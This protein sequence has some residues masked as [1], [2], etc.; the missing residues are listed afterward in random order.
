MT[1]TNNPDELN[2]EQARTELERVVRALDDPEL[3][4]DEM[5]ALWEKGEKLASLCEQR[6]EGA[7]A[8]FDEV[9]RATESDEN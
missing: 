6:L 5:M 8:R 2:Y 9:T 4:L 7:R 3:P 1:A